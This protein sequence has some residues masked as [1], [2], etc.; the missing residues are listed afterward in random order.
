MRLP[1]RPCDQGRCRHQFASICGQIVH[2]VR[3]GE[4][5]GIG[6]TR[7]R[8]REPAHS[9]PQHSRPPN[10]SSQNQ[11]ISGVRLLFPHKLFVSSPTSKVASPAEG[12]SV[13]DIH[14]GP[15]HSP[16]RRCGGHRQVMLIAYTASTLGQER[17]ASVISSAISPSVITRAVS[18]TAYLPGV[19]GR[20]VVAGA[21]HDDFDPGRYGVQP[22]QR[23]RW[24]AGVLHCRL[25]QSS[26]VR[27]TRTW[28]GL[29]PGHASTPCCAKCFAAAARNPRP[30][31]AAGSSRPEKPK[32][33]PRR[34]ESAGREQEQCLPEPAM[35]R[36]GTGVL[37]GRHHSLVDASHLARV[38]T[39]S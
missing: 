26:S 10:C 17:A 3:T 1:L 29:V 34:Y 6:E 38:G 13:P 8:P 35:N 39:G 14:F 32:W 24:R 30:C 9:P 18:G 19:R 27:G 33:W 22:R 15:C 20:P 23:Q 5:A 4:L 2:G 28:P 16:F 12:R 21:A 7:E 37:T 11:G 36:N 25:S 31:R